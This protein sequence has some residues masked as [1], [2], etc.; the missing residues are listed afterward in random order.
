MK[1][2]GHIKVSKEDLAKS[3]NLKIR[4]KIITGW[5]EKERKRSEMM[6]NYS[7]LIQSDLTIRISSR[8]GKT[9]WFYFS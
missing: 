7:N 6:K 8:G 1:D 9:Q 4:E 3:G 2:Q 5:R